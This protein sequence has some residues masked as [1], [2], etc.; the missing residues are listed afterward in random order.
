MQPRV[1]D[2]IIAKNDLKIHGSTFRIPKGMM[3]LVEDI[4]PTYN[5]I[6]I[7]GELENSVVLHKSQ[8]I[9]L[10]KLVIELSLL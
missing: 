1:G 2:Y 5:I 6:V 9:D 4:T 7:N 8:F 3:M 10:E